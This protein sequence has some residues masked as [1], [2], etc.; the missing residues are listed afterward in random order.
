[1]LPAR[2]QA[3]RRPFGLASARRWDVV[4]NALAGGTG[5]FS[6]RIGTVGASASAYTGAALLFTALMIENAATSPHGTV[7][8]GTTINRPAL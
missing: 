5:T 4:R 2:A 3:A 6:S 7:A 8:S 1:M